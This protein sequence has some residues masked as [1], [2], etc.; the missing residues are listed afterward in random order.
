LLRKP[1]QWNA[2]PGL[3]P[4]LESGGALPKLL[5]M[6]NYSIS[7]SA[8]A[9]SE[10]GKDNAGKPMRAGPDLVWVQCE[11]YRCM[12]YLDVKGKWVSFPTRKVLTDFVRVIK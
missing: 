3:E 10:P 6:L 7:M 12:A 8:K 5:N 11:G 4:W 1:E 2:D 9:H